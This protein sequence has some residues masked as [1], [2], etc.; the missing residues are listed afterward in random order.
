MFTSAPPAL[1]LVM[2]VTAPRR[3]AEKRP[4]P[5]A[6]RTRRPNRSLRGAQG[7]KGVAISIQ[8]STDGLGR[9]AVPVVPHLDG[10]QPSSSDPLN[11]ITARLA[12]AS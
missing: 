9:H 12:S 5:F 1:R 8:V 3:A 2:T 6:P 7:R 4:I 11:L 10:P